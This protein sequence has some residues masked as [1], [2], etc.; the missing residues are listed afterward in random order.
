ML[1]TIFFGGIV[2]QMRRGS[3]HG[4]EAPGPRGCGRF[5]WRAKA[6]ALTSLVPA[7]STWQV[8]PTWPPQ[9]RFITLVHMHR[10]L[11]NMDNQH[12]PTDPKTQQ[13]HPPK[14][15]HSHHSLTPHTSRLTSPNP[16]ISPLHLTPHRPPGRRHRQR[17]PETRKTPTRPGHIGPVPASADR[18]VQPPPRATPR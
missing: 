17:A 4:L 8:I 2:E 11:H 1:S 7:H 18:P 3:V 16:R 9:R 12:K 13:T 14:T 15:N 10:T 5:A 6:R